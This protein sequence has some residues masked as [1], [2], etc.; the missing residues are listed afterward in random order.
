MVV[1]SNIEDGSAFK[2]CYVGKFDGAGALLWMQE[3]SFGDDLVLSW[4]TQTS[5]G[6]FAVLGKSAFTQTFSKVF[7]IKLDSAGTLVWNTMLDQDVQD[8]DPTPITEAANGDLILAGVDS[9]LYG[10]AEGPRSF[11]IRLDAS[12][13]QIWGNVYDFWP[14]GMDI[15]FTLDLVEE[16]VSGDIFFTATPLTGSLLFLS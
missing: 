16:P 4:A 8:Q 15:L 2:K 12:G 3:I 5:D 9:S 1:A 14:A 7:V 11:I 13:T 10:A 6:G